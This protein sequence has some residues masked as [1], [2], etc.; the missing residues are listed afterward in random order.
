MNFKSDTDATQKES[1][2][3]PAQR[4]EG[5]GFRASLRGSTSIIGT[6]SHEAQGA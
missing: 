3:F 6:A 4:K 2:F 1:G 5:T